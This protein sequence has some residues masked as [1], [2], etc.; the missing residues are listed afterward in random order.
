MKIFSRYIIYAFM[1]L[2][3]LCEGIFL[4]L[5]LVIDF[6]QRIKDFIGAQVPINLFIEYLLCRIPLIITQTIPPAALIAAVILFSSLKRQNEIT[7]IKASGVNLLR[8]LQPL[9]STL[10][11]ICI[12][13]FL[14]SEIVVPY[15]SQKAN[16]ILKVDVRKQDP[17]LFYGSDQVWYKK[18]NCIYFI[19]H[20]NS[21]NITMEG[22]TLYF[23]NAS[24]QLE[25][26]IDAEKASW[27]KG[28]WQ[29]KKGIVQELAEGN[30]YKLNKF[31][32]LDLDML[33]S[34][35][36]FMKS[37]KESEEMS[38]WQLQQYAKQV[39]DEGYDNKAYLVDLY[40][41]TAIPFATLIIILTGIP[42]ALF[43][44]K[45]GAPVAVCMGIGVCFLYLVAFGIARSLG[46]SEILPPALS[47]WLG[48]LIFLLLGSYSMIHIER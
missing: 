35:T 38:Y 3:V 23:F 32:A 43:I 41:K 7:A 15:T 22:I 6:F 40:M 24:F 13:L 1:W 27:S 31:D 8:F 21:K 26:K 47:A 25:K 39:K 37:M 45:G 16:S 18:G 11:C 46:I 48:N 5:S 14:V 30:N 10:F 42:L 12:G 2:L 36:M 9:L 20:F 34:P 44:N 17:Q 33:E 28:V 4:F 29:L 19:K